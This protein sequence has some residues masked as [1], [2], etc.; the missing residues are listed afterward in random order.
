M[1]AEVELVEQSKDRPKFPFLPRTT[2]IVPQPADGLESLPDQPAVENS[3]KARLC[4][5]LAY[6]V[7]KASVQMESCTNR[8][9]AASACYRAGV[10]YALSSWILARTLTA[11]GWSSCSRI[12]NA[13]RQAVRAD[14]E[15]PKA[16]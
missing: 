15:S 4:L 5:R 13:R 6:V 10:T 11:R 9:G 3:F 12:A 14:S 16:W 1:T 7:A 2:R 8:A